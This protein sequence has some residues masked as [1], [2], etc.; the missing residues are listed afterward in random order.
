ME[1]WTTPGADAAS[2]AHH[3]KELA[4]AFASGLVKRGHTVIVVDDAPQ[5]EEKTRGKGGLVADFLNSVGCE[6]LF[7]KYQSGWIC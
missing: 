7:A 3:M 2:A 6:V 4:A 5:V 1:D